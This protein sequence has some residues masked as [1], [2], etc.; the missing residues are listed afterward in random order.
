MQESSENISNAENFKKT[1][2][3]FLIKW[4]IVYAI[5]IAFANFIP[6]CISK[7]NW[8]FSQLF[9]SWFMDKG[10]IFDGKNIHYSVITLGI[11]TLGIFTLGAFSIGI[12]TLGTNVVGGFSFGIN[13]IGIVAIGTNA[14]GVIAI[15]CNAVGVVAIGVNVIGIYAISYTEYS[16][17]R[18]LLAPH[19]QD[20]KAID[21]FSRWF[22][23]LTDSI[24]TQ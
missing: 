23:K 19:R 20:A 3:P 7:P 9:I 17:G 14:V 18:Y 22:P 15:G 11:N 6:I 24:S 8:E 21:F 2:K 10:A 16:K 5:F 1:F 4:S 13:A 12:I